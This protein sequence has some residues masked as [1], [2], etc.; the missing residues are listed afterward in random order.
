L[1]EV[2]SCFVGEGTP[3]LTFPADWL[4]AGLLGGRTESCFGNGAFRHRVILINSVPADPDCTKQNSSATVDRLTS[5]EGNDTMGSFASPV[6]ARF[7]ACKR[8]EQIGIANAK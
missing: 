8:P 1:E 7:P 5:G 6:I 4:A 2:V 3:H